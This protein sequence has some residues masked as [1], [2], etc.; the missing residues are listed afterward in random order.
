[1]F[2]RNVNRRMSTSR[3]KQHVHCRQKRYCQRARAAVAAAAAGTDDDAV[4]QRRLVD[5][6]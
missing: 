2:N 5:D 4:V 1:M 3:V 6:L